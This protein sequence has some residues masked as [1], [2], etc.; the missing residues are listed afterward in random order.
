[1]IQQQ[2]PTDGAG[3]QVQHQL[4]NPFLRTNVTVMGVVDKWWAGELE[5]VEWRQKGNR[6]FAQQ[7][8]ATARNAYDKSI[9]SG[10]TN[11]YY[12]PYNFMLNSK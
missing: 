7:Q 4:H 3:G 10:T 8:L 9:L 12:P 5:A 11:A 1:M 6:A 2:Q